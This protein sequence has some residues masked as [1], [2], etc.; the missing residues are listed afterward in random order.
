MFGRSISARGGR[1]AGTV[2]QMQASRSC[3]LG[4]YRCESVSAEDVDG[5]SGMGQLIDRMV[6]ANDEGPVK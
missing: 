6:I 3:V 1:L 2:S 4:Q 5:N